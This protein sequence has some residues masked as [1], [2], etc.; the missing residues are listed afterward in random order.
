MAD[1]DAIAF[2]GWA[3][4]YWS[5]GSWVYWLVRV[6]R[7]SVRD[8]MRLV[9]DLMVFSAGMSRAESSMTHAMGSMGRLLGSWI[10]V[11]VGWMEMV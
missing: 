7:S 8:W 3:V 11:L 6:L 2:E 1:A 4:G 5:F 9:V 10:S